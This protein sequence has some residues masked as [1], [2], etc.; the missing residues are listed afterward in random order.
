MKWKKYTIHT[1]A[2]AEDLIS[3]MLDELGVGGVE[4]DDGIALSEEDIEKQYI[5][6][7][8]EMRE[9]DGTAAVS[10]YLHLE[11]PGNKQEEKTEK[12][13]TVDDSYM[14]H[15]RIWSDG[16]VKKL[17]EDIRAG[18]AEMSAYTDIG[19]GRIEIG[20]T[21]ETDW[22][23]N[24]KAFFRPIRI[25]KILIIPS[26]LEV[27]EE[28]REETAAGT[29]K[30]IVI[31]PGT[32]F[33]TGSHETTRLCVPAIEKYAEPGSKV[34]DI[35][36]GSGILAMVA[37][38]LGAGKVYAFDVD[39]ACET[40]VADNCSQNRITN[41]DVFT[42]NILG[43]EEDL[44]KVRACGPF[45]VVIANILAPVI[46][47][48]SGKGIVDTL[49]KPGGVFITS[50]ILS[51]YADDVRHAMEENGSWQVTDTAAE[52]EWVQI[53]ARRI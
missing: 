11:E 29:L 48:L 17:E 28:Y 18:L 19:E 27:P 32:A 36:T 13:D 45:D 43:N 15:D 6:I 23:D 10:F 35:G 49:V 50:G 9:P 16:E 12:D 26:W 40:I 47:S 2:E 38:R 22:R 34:L 33:G 51:D 42:G 8:P 39:P 46:V 37:G 24:W 21:E 1:T 44:K 4:I 25:G 7:L 30:T 53:T 20:E 5:D 31:D 14:I 41:V 52:G 3:L